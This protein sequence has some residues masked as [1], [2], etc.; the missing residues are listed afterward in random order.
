[1]IKLLVITESFTERVDHEGFLK[2]RDGLLV[3]PN[4]RD[5]AGSLETGLGRLEP[6]RTGR[7]VGG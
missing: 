7:I 6:E 2:K 4:D 3:K 1:M 5:G